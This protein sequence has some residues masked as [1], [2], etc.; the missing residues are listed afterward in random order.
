MDSAQALIVL[1]GWPS[2]ENIFLFRKAESFG[3]AN[4]LRF[5]QFLISASYAPSYI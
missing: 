4:T 5:R 1:Q 2:R 3:K